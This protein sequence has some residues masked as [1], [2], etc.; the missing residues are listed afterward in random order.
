MKQNRAKKIFYAGRIVI[1]YCAAFC[2]CL[3]PGSAARAES[4]TLS[5]PR[6]EAAHFD[7]MIADDGESISASIGYINKQWKKGFRR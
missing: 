3:A 6:I 1:F 5:L 2:I 4:Y 7:E